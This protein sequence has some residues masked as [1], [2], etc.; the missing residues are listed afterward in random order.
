MSMHWGHCNVCDDFACLQIFPNCVICSI[1]I[2]KSILVI[3]SHNIPYFAD[4]D[5]CSSDPCHHDST[6]INEVNM[7]SCVCTPGYTGPLCQ[8]GKA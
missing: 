1:T 2:N 7:F 4:I 8:T 5:E 6:C 3:T